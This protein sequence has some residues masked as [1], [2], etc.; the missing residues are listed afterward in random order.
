ME[1][2]DE[3]FDDVDADILD[4]IMSKI[5]ASTFGFS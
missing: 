5:S 3:I 2:E 4:I 1:L